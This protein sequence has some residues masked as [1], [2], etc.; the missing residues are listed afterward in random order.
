MEMDVFQFL[1]LGNLTLLLVA[2]G[3]FVTLTRIVYL[4]PQAQNFIVE[5]SR[6]L[7]PGAETRPEPARAVR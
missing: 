5:R 4:V 1:N 7:S 6:A 2:L 3:G